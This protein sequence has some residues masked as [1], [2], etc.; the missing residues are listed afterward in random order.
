MKEKSL[1]VASHVGVVVKPA[2]T[3]V[4]VHRNWAIKAA[5]ELIEKSVESKGK[6]VEVKKFEGRGIYVDLELVFSQGSRF[7][8]GGTFHGKYAGLKLP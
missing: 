3:E 7:S 4:D 8:R 5:Q 6:H 2:L 1:K